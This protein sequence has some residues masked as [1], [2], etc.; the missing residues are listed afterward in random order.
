[1]L[2]LVNIALQLCREKTRYVAFYFTAFYSHKITHAHT[3]SEKC[4]TGVEKDHGFETDVFL[5]L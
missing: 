1:M 2:T 4:H 3:Q 5:P